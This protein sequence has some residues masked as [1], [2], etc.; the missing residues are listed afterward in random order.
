VRSISHWIAATRRALAD[1]GQMQTMIDNEL[2]QG[3]MEELEDQIVTGVGTGENF[4]GLTNV[5]GTTAQAW[6]TNILTTTRK[7]RTKVKTTGRAIPNAY[8]LH[9][10]DWETIDLLQDNEARY[11]FG[12]PSAIGT[13]RLWGLPVIESEAVTVG[14]GFVADFSQCVLWMRQEATILTSDS[15]Q[16]FFI[17]GLVA[18]L[19]EERAAFGV[20]RPA[21]IVEMDLTA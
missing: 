3:L 16:D 9:P 12:G 13:P 2:R 10:T 4:T 11:F 19:G 21:A 18:I 5:T 7:G 20:R 15:H 1:A 17:R 14:E 6:D 8:L